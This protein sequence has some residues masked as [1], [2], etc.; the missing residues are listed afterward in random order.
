MSD[1]GEHPKK[2][3]AIA[4]R[5]WRIVNKN[6]YPNTGIVDEYFCCDTL[7]Y[8]KIIGYIKDD[9]LCFYW[10]VGKI[11]FGAMDCKEMIFKLYKLAFDKIKEWVEENE[12]KGKI[13]FELCELEQLNIVVRYMIKRFGYNSYIEGKF[14][15]VQM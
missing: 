10:G 15:I 13:G 6:K 2:Y 1:R 4:N 9:V 12:Y 11:K 14:I 8:Q 5:K 7:P 3:L